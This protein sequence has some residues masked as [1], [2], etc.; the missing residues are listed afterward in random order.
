MIGEAESPATTR[1]KQVIGINKFT[2]IFFDLTTTTSIIDTI[3][4]ATAADAIING[5]SQKAPSLHK[6]DSVKGYKTVSKID[7]TI[8]LTLLKYVINTGINMTI[9]HRRTPINN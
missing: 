5:L 4:E 6:Y 1:I 3:R 8:G 9:V 7:E 2:P